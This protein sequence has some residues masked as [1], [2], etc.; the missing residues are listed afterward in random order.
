MRGSIHY[1]SPRERHPFIPADCGAI[2]V[3][4]VE[5]EL[6]GHARGAFTDASTSQNG[7]LQEAEGGTLFLDEINSL[8]LLAQA[9][10]LRFLQEKEYRPLGSP[11]ARKANVRVIAATS[12][13]LEEMVKEGKF[14]RDLYY[15][16]NV[17]SLTLPPLRERR[18]D[19][20]LLIRHFL[21]EHAV[22]SNKVGMEFSAEA[23]RIL[24]GC[25]WP[26][27]V[28]ELEHVVEHLE[29]Q[30]TLEGII[31]W[32]LLKQQINPRYLS[33]EKWEV[34]CQKRR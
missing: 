3:E 24:M 8:P 10:L 23:M 15:R 25:E 21:V 34:T 2:P 28:R 33:Q 22:K 13:D 16:L 9:K 26:G 32:W 29:A 31:E 14:R 27:N 30:D 1:L 18:E 19:I 4:L 17:L 20:P 7:L 11:K 12:S 5:N 6:F